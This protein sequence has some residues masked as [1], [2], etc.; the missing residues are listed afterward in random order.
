MVEERAGFREVT[1]K[2][3][4][5]AFTYRQHAAFTIFAFAHDQGAGGGVVVAVVEI[6]HFAAA[7][8]GGVEEFE[9]SAVAQA[10]GV[11]RIWNGEET[12]DFLFVKGFGELGGL[13]ARQIEVGGGVGWD[14]AGAAEPGEEAADAAEPGKLGVGDEWLA[15]A[16]AAVVVEEELVG[17]EIGAGEGSGIIDTARIRPRGELAQC[18]AVGFDGGLGVGAGGEVREEGVRMSG[19][20]LRNGWLRCGCATF[21]AATHGGEIGESGLAWHG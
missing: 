19:D 18:P 1:A 20:A 11:G 5:G 4:G 16:R 14:G 2:P 3:T 21:A 12:V 9:D 10:E 6:G 7:D 17:F 13:F 8:A 15:A